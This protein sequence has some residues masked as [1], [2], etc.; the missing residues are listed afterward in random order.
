[1]VFNKVLFTGLAVAGIALTTT[2][3]QLNKGKSTSDQAAKVT[4]TGSTKTVAQTATDSLASLQNL[5][6]TAATDD[7]AQVTD[8]A[9]TTA[10]ADDSAQDNTAAQVQTVQQ[11]AQQT[12]SSQ[13][14]APAA[15]AATTSSQKTSAP[16]SQSSSNGDINWLI[17][18]ESGGNVHASNG[19]FYGIGQLSPSVYAQYSGGQDY[20]GNYNVQLQAMQGYIAGRYGDVNTAINHFQN[21]G[22]Y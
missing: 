15:A 16:A 4:T 7:S 12:T 2:H 17:S 1:M 22:W 18:R 19:S 14:Q 5:E 3:Q 10:T 21:N 11:P 8:T 9:D 6:N 13:S 20:V